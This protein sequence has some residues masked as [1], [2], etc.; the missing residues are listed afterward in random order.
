MEIRA[1]KGIDGRYHFEYWSYEDKEGGWQIIDKNSIEA[2]SYNDSFE[3]L[4]LSNTRDLDNGKIIV[5]ALSWQKMEILKLA[6]KQ[7]LENWLESQM[8]DSSE[9]SSK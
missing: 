8:Q 2:D 6:K 5:I 9:D 4:F 1:Y 7:F 3:F